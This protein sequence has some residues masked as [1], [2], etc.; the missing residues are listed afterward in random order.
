MYASKL[1]FVEL[2]GEVQCILLIGFPSINSQGTTATTGI[3]DSLPQA[4]SNPIMSDLES[5]SSQ[6]LQKRSREEEERLHP[7]FYFNSCENG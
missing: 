3:S 7:Q 5:S 2:E 1:R 6:D 4:V